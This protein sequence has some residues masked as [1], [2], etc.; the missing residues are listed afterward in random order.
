MSQ[1]PN[2]IGPSSV[3]RRLPTNIMLAAA[4]RYTQYSPWK[5]V[6]FSMIFPPSGYFQEQAARLGVGAGDTAA[7]KGGRHRSAKAR[8]GSRGAP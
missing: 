2:L 6:R 5:T 7:T 1:W 8:N 4:S 3:Y